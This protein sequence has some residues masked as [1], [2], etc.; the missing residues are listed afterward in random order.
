MT[1]QLINWF[2]GSQSYHVPPESANTA[3]HALTLS[4]ADVRQMRVVDGALHF[5]LP[6]RDCKAVERILENK[7]IGARCVAHHG[8]G[9]L[10][11]RYRRRWGIPIG[12]LLF[13]AVLWLS[14]Q[15]IWTVDVSGNTDIPA[16][17]IIRR[18]DGLGGGIGTYIPKVDFDDLHNSFLLK[19]DDISWISVNVRGTAAH[20]EVREMKLPDRIIDEDAPHNLV[21]REDG[22][23]EY[24]EILRGTP[25][26]RTDE[27]VRRGE[28]LASGIAQGKHGLMFSHAM[29]SVMAEVKR[30]AH[31]EVPLESYILSATGARYSEKYL[32]IFGISLKFFENTEKMSQEYDK[33]E[34]EMSSS[35][36]RLRVF[37]AVELPIAMSEVAFTE[38]ERVPVILTEDEA[39]AQAYRKLREECAV[40]TSG[41]ELVSRKISAGLSGN[42]YIIDCELTVVCDIA[43]ERPIYMND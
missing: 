19:Y 28:L 40:L 16:D 17:V 41:C 27:L 7:G 30:S 18:L 43:E 10:V 1:A 35:Q 31:I 32:N 38:Y 9:Y 34:Y 6:M 36:N 8:F 37:D 3:A 26:A 20:I 14:E 12:I 39:K 22:I 15:F 29:G 33:I 11:E 25:V 42:A 21:A 5:T 4:G 13:F 24:M 23:I 2:L